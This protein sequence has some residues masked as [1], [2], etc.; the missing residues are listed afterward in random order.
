MKILKIKLK[1]LSLILINFLIFLFLSNFVF[2]NDLNFEIKGN[3]Y[4]DSDVIISLLKDIP[5]KIDAEY[6]NE[7]INTLNSSNLFSNVSVKLIDQKYIITVKEFPNINKI[8][9]NN[10]ERLD[11]EELELIAIDANLNTFN[12][13]SINSFI[14]EIDKI[15]K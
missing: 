1:K 11:D 5:D 9:F 4:T 7:I 15:Y 3:Q 12:K 10:N 2:A 8:Y 13:K 14:N 6:S